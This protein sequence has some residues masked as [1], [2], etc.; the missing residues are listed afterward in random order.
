MDGQGKRMENVVHEADKK[1]RVWWNP[2]HLLHNLYDWVLHWADTSYGLPALFLL[3]FAE[4][5]FFPVPPDILL[6]ALAIA[7]PTRAFRYALVCSLGSILGGIFGFFLG[8]QFY[9]LIG[10][11]IIAF[12]GYQEYYNKVEGL[13]HEYGT[14]AVF[15]AGLT[16]IPY[17]VFTIASGAFR[18]PFLKFMFASILSRSARFF[19]VSG[20]IWL[21]GPKIKKFI[22]KYFNLL[23]IVFTAALIGGFLVIRYVYPL[24]AK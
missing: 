13:Y 16:P 11:P 15:V 21:F 19:L 17:K 12:Y 2:F 23:V 22:D 3:A 24:L 7:V 10:E 8:W 20:L 4:S 5:S 9:E 6:I 18:F 1:S 14:W